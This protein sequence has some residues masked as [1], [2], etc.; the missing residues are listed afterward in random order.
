MFQ[1]LIGASDLYPLVTAMFRFV[2]K[3]VVSVFAERWYPETNTFH[4]PFREMTI[5][6]ENVSCLLRILVVG[7]AVSI[8]QKLSLD[9]AVT[10]VFMQLRV[11]AEDVKEEL[12][13]VWGTFVR[14]EWLR[15]MFINVN[16]ESN[17]TQIECV[18][19]A[20]LLFLLSCTLFVDKYST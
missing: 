18:A 9:V 20:Y 11:L 16:D 19:K 13:A 7:R 5:T 6:F 12:V 1:L 2:N 3:I 15:T 17:L 4:M 14:F 10:L 8:L